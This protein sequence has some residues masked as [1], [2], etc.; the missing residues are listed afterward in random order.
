MSADN[1]RIMR[2]KALM[3]WRV[4][5]LEVGLQADR[6]FR[7]AAEDRGL[8]LPIV[9]VRRRIVTLKDVGVTVRQLAE[10]FH[11]LARA[12]RAADWSPRWVR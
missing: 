8:V 7:T 5:R 10:A 2:Q 9:R 4:A 6:E 11:E 1:D 3:N 12:A